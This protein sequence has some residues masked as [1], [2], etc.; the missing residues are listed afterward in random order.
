MN[1]P[2]ALISICLIKALYMLS[3]L[4]NYDIKNEKNVKKKFVFIYKHNNSCIDN[5]KAV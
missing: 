2:S 4:L 3:V 1:H 5:E